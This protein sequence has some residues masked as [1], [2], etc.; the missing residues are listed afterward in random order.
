MSAFCLHPQPL[1][2]RL[3]KRQA[4]PLPC[5]HGAE[6]INGERGI[7]ISINTYSVGRVHSTGR[8]SK[9][10]ADILGFKS[11]SIQV[12]GSG[13]LMVQRYAILIEIAIVLASLLSISLTIDLSPLYFVAAGAVPAFAPLAIQRLYGDRIAYAVARI[14]VLAVIIAITLTFLSIIWVSVDQQRSIS[15]PANLVTLVLAITLCFTYSLLRIEEPAAKGR[16]QSFVAIHRALGGPS[17]ILAFCVAAVLFSFI[18]LFVTDRHDSSPTMSYIHEKL[19]ERGIIP[20]ICLMLLNWGLIILIGKAKALLREAK[21][22][23]LLR[24]GISSGDVLTRSDLVRDSIARFKTRDRENLSR[25]ALSQAEISEYCEMTW[26]VAHSSYGMIGFLAWAIPILGFLGTVLG[27][28]LS[29]SELGRIMVSRENTSQISAALGEAIAPLGIA[30][31][32][33]LVALSFSLLLVF[34][35]TLVQRWETK[36]LQ[37][38]EYLVISVTASNELRTPQ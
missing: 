30:F 11:R 12:E 24:S 1:F 9:D 35:Q 15:L 20:P 14:V 10:M 21:A 13:V 31:D 19:L 29:V 22:L 7:Q 23:T 25:G 33:T 26:Q 36:I 4:P 17:L 28:S 6:C 2:I 3:S 34:G 38:L 8:R 32:T 16:N 27:I 37:S 5:S 18:L